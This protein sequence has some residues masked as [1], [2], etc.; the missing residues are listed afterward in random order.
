MIA[1]H[2]VGRRAALVSGL[3]MAVYPY[4]VWHDVH[5]VRTGLDTFFSLS[6]ILCLLQLARTKKLAW[7]LAAG[8]AMFAASQT[9]NLLLGFVPVAALWLLLYSKSWQWASAATLAVCLGAA[10]S[11][12]PWVARN[13]ALHGRFVPSTTDNGI[14]FYKNNNPFIL[15]LVRQNK[16]PDHVMPYIADTLIEPSSGVGEAEIESIYFQRGLDWIR[17]NPGEKL[18]LMALLA[19]NYWD[20]TA[21]RPRADT[22]FEGS[23]TVLSL[24]SLL[25]SL[26]YGPVFVL[27]VTGL[28][29]ALPRD[30][31][32]WLV[33]SLFAFNT[34][35][36]SATYATTRYRI[37]FD[38][39]LAAYAAGT[40]LAVLARFGG[41]AELS[42]GRA[43]RTHLVKPYP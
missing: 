5:V 30:R 7:G 15:D 34:L 21:I 11:L 3:M 40:V 9:T 6:A 19:A 31:S 20:P 32:S 39:I 29:L 33:L 27:G 13:Y 42:L 4:P 38:G 16:G 18:A 22:F 43:A 24:K 2:L 41:R 35:L 25:Y 26:S 12:A 8:A 36:Y 23:Q 17:E 14:A 10:L 1:H 28:V 37:P